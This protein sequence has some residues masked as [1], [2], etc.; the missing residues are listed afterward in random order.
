[1]DKRHQDPDST[2]QPMKDPNPSAP[3]EKTP[4]IK[5]LPIIPEKA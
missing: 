3:P 2:P 5:D 1:M 4:E